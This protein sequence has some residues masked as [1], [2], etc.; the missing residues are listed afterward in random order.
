MK[1]PRRQFL[2]LAAGAAALPAFS[3]IANMRTNGVRSLD[4]C[5]W[6]CHHR[7]ILSADPWLDHV[8]V[9]TFGP[10]MVMHQVRA[11]SVPTPGR[12]GASNRRG[13]EI[14]LVR[15]WEHSFL[16]GGVVRVFRA[17]GADIF[18]PFT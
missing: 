14:R 5:G 2:H 9:P 18:H 4:V 7:A 8:P 16:S 10:R 13:S 11:S 3:R 12:T 15:S 6:L 1:I 17:F